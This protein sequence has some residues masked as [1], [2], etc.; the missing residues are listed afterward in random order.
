MCEQNIDNIM[1]RTAQFYSQPTYVRGGMMPVFAGS[2]RQRGG[3]VLGALKSFFLP[4]LRTVGRKGTR[5]ALG[6]ATDVIGDVTSGRNIKESLKRRG[7]SRAKS[8]GGDLLGTT[9]N[10]AQ[11]LLSSRPKAA[12]IRRAVPSRKRP[13]RKAKQSAKRRKGNF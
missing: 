3:S 8:L 2:R 6:L 7:I 1:D 5:A 13:A 12:P 10:H 11:S 4:L 9:V